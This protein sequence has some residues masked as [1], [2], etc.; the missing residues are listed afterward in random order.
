MLGDSLDVPIVFGF[1]A[2]DQIG[3]P[4]HFAK[5]ADNNNVLPESRIGFSYNLYANVP[6]TWTRPGG[7][8]LTEADISEFKLHFEKA[9]MDGD[10]SLNLMLPFYHTISFS[11][12]TFTGTTITGEEGGQF[13]NL[14]FGFKRVLRR[15]DN[16]VVS[17]GL[18]IEAPTAQDYAVFGDTVV[19]DKWFLTP[20]VGLQYTPNDRWYAHGF[21]SYRF[22]TGAN[23][24]LVFP[25]TDFIQSERLMLDGAVGY[26]MFRQDNCRRFITGLSPTV[27]LH[28]TT[29]TEDQ[30]PLLF[31]A[32]WFNRVDML[33]LTLGATAELVN[34]GTIATGIGIPLRQG[35]FPGGDLP[36]DRSMDWE[37]LVQYN[38]R[39]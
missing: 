34:G 19:N 27:E 25:G 32:E 13:G 26:W 16:H 39:F 22:R 8:V 2:G 31:T 17:G 9:F 21:A 36:T 12:S 1:V 23:E 29:Y 18:L 4:R 28:Y 33:N 15:R 24:S 6:K 11:Q 3:I 10:W 38:L 35:R 5:V 30:N 20:Y 37:L 7:N 14:A